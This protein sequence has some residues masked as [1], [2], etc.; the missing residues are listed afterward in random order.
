MA[1]LI[2]SNVWNIRFRRQTRPI[3]ALAK[4]LKYRE[5]LSKGRHY[6]CKLLEVAKCFSE[7]QAQ[8]QKAGFTSMSGTSVAPAQITSTVRNHVMIDWHIVVKY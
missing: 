6:V 1:S 4:V 8:F 7:A 2:V 3:A 5:L